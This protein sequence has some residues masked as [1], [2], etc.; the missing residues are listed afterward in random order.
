MLMQGKSIMWQEGDRGQNSE[1]LPQEEAVK[2]R[3]GRR[4]EKNHLHQNQNTKNCMESN[5]CR[6]SIC[7]YLNE[8]CP[9]DYL[10]CS[11][12]RSSQSVPYSKAAL[13]AQGEKK[14][15]KKKKG[16]GFSWNKENEERTGLQIR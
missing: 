5:S 14:K 9:C 1:Y 12:M 6:Y 8:F 13:R 11:E 2:C 7:A 16:G 15:L 3:C 10:L 4:M